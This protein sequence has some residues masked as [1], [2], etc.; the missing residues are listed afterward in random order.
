MLISSRCRLPGLLLQVQRQWGHIISSYHILQRILRGRTQKETNLHTDVRIFP[1]FSKS[2]TT[3]FSVTKVGPAQDVPVD[4]S[5][6]TMSCGFIEHSKCTDSLMGETFVQPICMDFQG[7][8]ALIAVFGVGDIQHSSSIHV[9]DTFCTC[10]QDLAVRITGVFIL[11]YRIFD[12]F[13]KHHPND[14]KVPIHAECFGGPFRIYA[15]KDFPGLPEST[16]L[17]KVGLHPLLVELGLLVFQS[18]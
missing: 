15:S 17:T 18:C 5:L 3:I 7:R 11:R 6:S 4:G 8:R 14:I 13:S 2:I 9:D 1:G 16:E 10:F 12:V